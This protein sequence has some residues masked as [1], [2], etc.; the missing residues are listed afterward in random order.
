LQTNLSDNFEP[1]YVIDG[2]SNI[3]QE[4][5]QVQENKLFQQDIE[6]QLVTSTTV[7]STI[8]ATSI[9]TTTINPKIKCK[10]DREE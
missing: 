1:R 4:F 3:P 6:T 10:A 7:T 2:C 5:L 8:P 9:P